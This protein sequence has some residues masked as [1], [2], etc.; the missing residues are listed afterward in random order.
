MSA[1]NSDPTCLTS[2][3]P[4][5]AGGDVPGGDLSLPPLAAAPSCEWRGAPLH[6]VVR[7]GDGVIGNVRCESHRRPRRPDGSL[8][9]LSGWFSQA[10]ALETLLVEANDT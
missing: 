1:R 2:H 9:S 5:S 6:T 4:L 10:A 8:A 3:L 7:S